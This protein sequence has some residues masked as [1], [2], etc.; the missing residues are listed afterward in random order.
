MLW[1]I[2]TALALRNFLDLTMLGFTRVF[3]ENHGLLVFGGV[4][5]LKEIPGPNHYFSLRFQ[6]VC[7]RLKRSDFR[8]FCFRLLV[9]P[10]RGAH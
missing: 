9:P 2:G 5:A 4:W 6:K 8:D 3:G 7:F 1:I 10:S